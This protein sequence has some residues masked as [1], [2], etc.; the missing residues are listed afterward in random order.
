MFFSNFSSLFPVK[1]LIISN[2]FSAGNLTV[3]SFQPFYI[4]ALT[5][6]DLPFTFSTNG[7]VAIVIALFIY[8]IH[9]HHLFYS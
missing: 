5:S 9:V 3:K 4:N 2:I 7:E 8:S 1:Y 6:S